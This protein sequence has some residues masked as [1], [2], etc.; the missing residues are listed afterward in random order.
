MSRLNKKVIIIGLILLIIISSA[1]FLVIKKDT[2]EEF[3][4]PE[5]EEVIFNVDNLSSWVVYWDLNV[6]NEI[7]ALN[8]KLSSISYFA[9]NFNE[10]NKLSIPKGL[11]EYYNSTKKYKFQKYITIV[12]DVIYNDGKSSVKDKSVL[13]ELLKSEISRKEHIDEIIALAKENE[14][15]GIEIDYEQIKDYTLWENYLLFI[16]ELYEEANLNNLNLRVVL[17]P[18]IPIEKL[19][20]I[21][22]PTYIIMCY[23]LH[24]SFSEAGEKTNEAF[25]KEL[26]EKMNKIPG[27]KEFAIPTG[28]FDWSKE[29]E[30]KAITEIETN[31]VIKDNDIKVERDAESKYLFF[32]YLDENSIEHEVWYAD[33]VTLEYLNKIIVESGHKVN[34]WRLGGNEFN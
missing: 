28:G 4:K 31:K 1:I 22:G 16:K 34:L 6:E 5:K 23:N 3:K 27:N 13:E 20:F 12:N 18:S 19:N 11:I 32:K 9:A 2:K 33:K 21:D 10:E 14:F 25:I 29:E 15:D 17:E 7:E 8:Y 26:I 24:G 30:V